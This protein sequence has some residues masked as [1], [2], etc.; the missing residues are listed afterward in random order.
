VSLA[1]QTVG[2]IEQTAEEDTQPRSQ[3]LPEDDT[4]TPRV[5]IYDISAWIFAAAALLLVFPL[6]LLPALLSGLLVYQLVHISAPLLRLSRLSDSRI[7]LVVVALLAA[8]IISLLAT[9]VWSAVHFFRDETTSLSVLLQKMADIINEGRNKLPVWLANYLPAD[10]ETLRRW[11]VQWLREHASA[12]QSVGKH[13]GRIIAYILMGML[14]GA[15][16]VLR[17]A[18]SARANR[19]LARALGERATRLSEA[20]RSIVFAQVRISA[21][22]TL[23]TWLYLGVALPLLDIHLPLIKTMIIITFIAGLLPIIGNLISNSVILVVSLSNSIVVAGS[24]L[25]FLLVIH[26]LEYFLN[27]RIVGSSIR[28]P[29]WELLLA[30]LIME[31]AFGISGLIVAPI[32][33]AYVRKELSDRGLV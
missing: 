31:S 11:F 23:F 21:L 16:I 26:K 27:A 8:I 3:T 13:A 32:Y 15:V 2:R 20:F 6:Q 22:N 33:Y 5:T 7:K 18:D 1:P 17:E 19:P 12:L 10:A 25:I 14:L 28:V 30:M 29:V 24:S 4:I 9:V